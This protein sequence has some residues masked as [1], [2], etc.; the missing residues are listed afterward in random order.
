MLTFGIIDDGVGV[1]PTYYK[2]RQVVNG[3]FVCVLLTDKFPLNK[4]GQQQLYNAGFNAIEIL[5]SRGCDVITLSSAMLSS[6]YKRLSLNCPVPL[7]ASEA[8]ILHAST[9]TASNVLVCAENAI[10]LRSSIPNALCC[11][12]D[13]FPI[14]AEGGNERKIVDY[15]DK[16]LQPY[17]GSFDCIALASSSMNLY[18]HCFNRVCPNARVFDSLDGVARKIRKKYGKIAKDDGICQILNPQ[19]ADITEKYSIFF[20]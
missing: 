15:L 1:F 10:C 9:Y 4:L 18:K 16:C 17:E 14:L 6:L 3:N 8:P 2:L 19:G 5:V 20:E 7:Y 12:M 11:V 13:D